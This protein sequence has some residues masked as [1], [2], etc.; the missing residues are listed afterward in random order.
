MTGKWLP[1]RLC[2][3]A[4]AISRRWVTE[5]ECARA[6]IVKVIPYAD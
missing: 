5:R 1:R 2:K 6:S 3:G 4:A